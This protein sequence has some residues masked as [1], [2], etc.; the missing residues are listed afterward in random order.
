MSFA[1]RTGKCKETQTGQHSR[2]NRCGAEK[3]IVLGPRRHQLNP[4][5]A[6]FDG[7]RVAI[8]LV[9]RDSRF[10]RPRQC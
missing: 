10:P 2:K 1:A 9:L 6:S 5:S 4:E 8:P 7:M 3:L